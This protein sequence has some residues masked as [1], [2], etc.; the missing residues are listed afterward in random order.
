MIPMRKIWFI[1]TFFIHPLFGQDCTS[2]RDISEDLWFKNSLIYNVEV[3]TF[4]DSDGDGMG[5]FQGLIQK[6]DYLKALGVD[7]VWLSPF[8]PSPGLDDGYDVEDHYGVN[9]KYG[10]PGDLDDFLYQAEKRGIQVLMDVVLN[11]TSDQ[12]PWF[13][14]ARKDPDSPYRSW[15]LW[16]KERPEGWNEGMVFPGV[17]EATWTLDEEAGEYYYHRFY[18]F[19]PDLN[20]EHPQVRQEAKK[21]LGYWTRQG[22]SGYRLDAVPFIIELPETEREEPM[23]D[24]DWLYELRRFVQWRKGDAV[25]LGEANVLP[26]ETKD[27]FGEE[28]EGMHMMFNFYVNQHLFLA[29]ASGEPQALINALQATKDIPKAS[30]WAHFLRNHDE[31]DL[32]RL[33]E[34]Q[35]ELVYQKFGPE[36]DM[37][38]YERGIRRRL[39]PMLNNRPMLEMAYSLMFSLPGTPVFRYGD[40]IGMGDDLSLPERIAVRTPMQWTDE[41]NA[42][43]ST[44]EET[45]RPVIDE[46]EYGYKKV[47]VA[48]QYRDDQY[49]LNWMINL[50]KLRKS[51]PEIGLGDWEVLK[52]NSANSLAI[53]YSHQGQSVVVV[54]NFAEDPQEV[55]LETQEKEET[56]FD[57][58]DQER[59]I[60]SQENT[61]TLSL[62]GYGYRW[63]KVDEL[64]P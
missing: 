14:E 23:H 7:A 9:P 53:R 25:I 21:I 44:A 11:H 34:Q 45:F 62:E 2:G 61:V 57:L 8:Q 36:E 40:E 51:C 58:V 63:Y 1:L 29:L 19:Q 27:Y 13:Q 16:S 33:S 32:G 46:G 42:G 4:K 35:R 20:F 41:K 55:Q 31:L 12:H 56:W 43:F 38:L 39:A 54:H 10:T 64:F 6:L 18:E 49:F 28:G 24:F 3:A 50:I 15:Y 37:Q 30:Q 59:D 52:T 22:L 48:A 26:D 5:D 60:K 17:Q 47:N